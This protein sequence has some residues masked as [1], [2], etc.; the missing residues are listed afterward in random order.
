M[1][2]IIM[3][4]ICGL[5]GL[6]VLWLGYGLA[7]AGGSW[8]YIVMALGLI[9]SGIGLIRRHQSGLGV[10]A[11]TLIITFLWTLYEVG[12]DKWQWIPRGALLLAFGLILCIPVFASEIRARSGRS[13][14]GYPLL[15]GTVAVII[16]LA[17]GSWFIDP[18]QIRGALT[19]QANIGDG[20]VD[21]SGV[22]YPAEDWTAYGGT[23]LGQ[24]Y[25]ALRDIDAGNVKGLTLAWEHHTGDLRKADEDSKEYTFEATPIKVNGLL[26]FC[27]PH[28][29]IQALV[30]ET[31]A[32]KWSFDPM[33][34]RDPFY[35]H[36]TCRGVSWNDS[37]GY[38]APAS[39]TPEAQ[40]AITAAVAE[41]PKRIVASSVDARLYTVNADTGALC[42][43]FGENGYVNLLEGMTDTER[44]SYQQTS[45][46]LVTKDLIILGSAIADNYYE[47]N[48]SGVIRAY[49]VRTGK[50]VWKFDAGKPDDTAP[51]APSE[52]YVPNSNVAW[53]QFA[54]DE[55]LGM[56]YI[57]F[58]NASPDQVGIA[59]TPE[60]EAFVDALAA[61]D[62]KTGQLKWKF[63]TS[64]HDLWDRDN[65]SQP[66]LL[67]LPKDGVD[68][69]AIII[70]TKIG[71][72]W[73]LDRRDGTPILPVSE[74]QVSTDSDIPGEKLSAVQP[75]SS[76]TFAPAPLREADMWGASP[77]DQ[78]Q[79]RTTF[80]SNRYDGNSWTPPTTTGSIVW[81][82]NIGVF[83]WGSVAVDPVNKWLIG[84]PQYLPY[85][86]KLY[87]RPE[88][89]LTKPMFQD[90]MS[91]GEAK[92]GNENLGGPYAVSIQ[93]F[94]SGLGVPCNTPP[95][96]MRVGVD[97][98][99]G[100]T[101]WK[102]RNGTVAGQ[103]FM[104][105]SFPIPFEMGML[106][107]GGTLTTA[108][109]VAFTAA[110]LD[111]IMRAYDMQT[112]ETLWQARLP[113]GGQA[114]PMTYRGADGKQYIVVAAGGHGSL[115]TT[116]GD[117]VLAYRLE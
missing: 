50:V 37:I 65:P 22:A 116:P 8:F 89:D 31:G 23:N 83:N 68:T 15:G 102:Y 100:K 81:P 105:V 72:L 62:L 78:I 110:A 108:G 90:D 42:T 20:L 9:L 47:N 112:G 59:R 35:Q 4:A 6:W 63:Q 7:A 96:G 115:G 28:N 24:R 77:I 39:D 51:L 75:M 57:P 61:L 104:G 70:P 16:V 73:V 91:G 33:M 45:A 1:F 56:V 21:P 97:L 101:A 46:P 14:P 76:L 25:S 79:C 80:V 18:A 44:A 49:D 60:Q 12:F 74:V 10:Y 58:G 26:Y 19:R 41:C 30:P 2:S 92:P 34:K 84:T 107:H 99:N 66:V 94:R 98:T 17:V 106:A 52:T 11:V 87:P 36:Q 82:G 29:I 64:Y 113:A 88:G 53:T 93:H 54:A 27:T 111:D 67:N 103:K 95:W 86:Y 13:G 38:T 3:G 85:I 40:A 117:S 114:T 32:V 71:N 43:T 109:G 5:F 55:T 69:P 48:P